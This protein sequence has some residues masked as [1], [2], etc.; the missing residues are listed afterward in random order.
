METALMAAF[1]AL[2]FF[3]VWV[4]TGWLVRGTGSHSGSHPA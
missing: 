1:A 3:G 2:L 4:M